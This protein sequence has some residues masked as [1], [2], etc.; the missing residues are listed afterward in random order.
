MTA[1]IYETDDGGMMLEVTAWRIDPCGHCCEDCPHDDGS[2]ACVVMFFWNVGIAIAL[3]AS[4][5]QARRALRDWY[6]ERSR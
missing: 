4:A 2:M 3:A 6:D 5:Q 1:A